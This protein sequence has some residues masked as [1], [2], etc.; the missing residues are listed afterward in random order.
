MNNRKQDLQQKRFGKLVAI[1]IVGVNNGGHSLWECVCDCGEIKNVSRCSLLGGYNKSCGCGQGRRDNLVGKKFG[2]LLVQSFS[3][4]TKNRALYWNCLCVCGA[5]KK[6]KA[7]SLRHGDSSSCGCEQYG[8]ARKEKFKQT[9]LGR[10][11]ADN[12]TKNKE[13]RLRAAISANKARP[14]VYWETGELFELEGW[15]DLV[16]QFWNVKKI[17][18]IPQPKTFTLGELKTYTPDFY[19]PDQDLWVEVKGRW[20]DYES[21][22][23]WEKFHQLFPN[24]ELWNESKLK[25]L[26][27]LIR[28]K[29]GQTCT[30]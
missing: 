26:G 27:I 6:I 8:Q 3:H 13:V 1:S 19:L 7:N 2:K 10:F 21:K 18:Y 12:P 14:V 22:Q 9:C 5:I 16:A 11:G 28:R 23:K 29:N 25:Q 20:Y 30:K 15:E 4:K 24:S 17:K